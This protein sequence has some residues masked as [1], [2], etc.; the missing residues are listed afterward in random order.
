[1]LE[2][3][4]EQLLLLIALK[5]QMETEMD[6]SE[7]RE[8]AF[9]EARILHEAAKVKNTKEG[10]QFK[11]QLLELE[12]IVLEAKTLVPLPPLPPPFEE[13]PED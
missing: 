1:M 5:K 9:I 2:Q 8:V 4:K 11:K 12:A 7:Q 3:A 10:K 6:K 13:P